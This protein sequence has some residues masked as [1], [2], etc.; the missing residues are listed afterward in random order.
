MLFSFFLMNLNCFLKMRSNTRS[1]LLKMVFID[2]WFFI[3]SWRK[4]INCVSKTQLSAFLRAHLVSINGHFINAYFLKFIFCIFNC[5]ISSN[6]MWKLGQIYWLDDAY[7]T[8]IVSIIN[9]LNKQQSMFV[10]TALW[11]SLRSLSKK[12]TKTKLAWSYHAKTLQ[13][14]S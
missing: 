1:G 14:S 9:A 8:T 12:K 7:W 4:K 11:D 6:K 13:I 2:L 5:V 10:L 3:Q